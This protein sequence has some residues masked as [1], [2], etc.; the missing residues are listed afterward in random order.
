M[1]PRSWVAGLALGVIVLGGAG[2]GIAS[3]SNT[4]RPDVTRPSRAAQVDI[5]RV[6]PL[7]ELSSYLYTFDLRAIGGEARLTLDD[8]DYLGLP[9]SNEFVLRVKGVVVGTNAQTAFTVNG[10]KEV[11]WRNG[12]RFESRVNGDPIE[13]GP[14]R[15]RKATSTT[16]ACVRRSSTGTRRLV[17]RQVQCARQRQHR[18]GWRRRAW[19]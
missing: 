1:Q 10:A 4:P 11:D 5:G 9:P 13:K 17:Q 3:A 8:Y 7:A 15:S 14:G 2:M 6:T 19:R 16:G 12:D 18:S